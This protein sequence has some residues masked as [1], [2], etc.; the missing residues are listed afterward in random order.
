MQLLPAL[1][2]REV[3][4]EITRYVLR[5]LSVPPGAEVMG[6]VAGE[7]MGEVMGEVIRSSAVM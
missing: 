6:E 2:A 1:L 3:Y 5:N 7:V 4:Q